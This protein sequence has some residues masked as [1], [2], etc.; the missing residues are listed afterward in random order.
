MESQGKQNTLWPGHQR[1][2]RVWGV[3]HCLAFSSVARCAV[4]EPCVR[5]QE[6]HAKVDGQMDGWAG[7]RGGQQMR[8]VHEKQSERR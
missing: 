7:I 1:S 4:H 2:M 6:G 5:P 3:G 8:V